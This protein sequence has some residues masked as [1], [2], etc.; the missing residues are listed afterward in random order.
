MTDAHRSAWTLSSLL[1]LLAVLLIPQSAAASTYRV[2]ECSAQQGSVSDAVIEGETT[3]YTAN[4]TCAYAPNNYLQIGTSGPVGAGQSKAWTFTAPN[5]TR[6]NRATG[7]YL[8]Q[9]QADHGG[10]QSYFFYRAVN[11]GSDQILGHQGAGNV[12]SLFDT[13][14]WPNAGAITRVGIGVECKSGATCPSRNAIYSR[15]S[16]LAFDMED[17][18][19]P[20]APVVSGP[21]L[22]GW[23]NGSRQLNFSVHDTG[24]GVSAGNTAVNGTFVDLDAFC[25]PALDGS[26]AAKQMQPCPSNGSSST[27]L[28]TSTSAFVEGDNI[29]T[30]CVYEYGEASIQRGCTDETVKVD[31]IAPSSPQGLSI[32][33]GEDWR[34]DNRFDLSWANPAQPNAPIVGASIRITG[35]GGYDA[36]TYHPG[37]DRT[38]VNDIQVPARGEYSARVYLR[39]AAGNEAAVNSSSAPLRFDDTVPMG[40]EPE[41]ANG[42]ISRAELASGYLQGWE[43]TFGLEVPPS[44]IAGYRVVVNGNSD[45]DPCSGATDPRACGGP[46]TEAGIDN[47]FRTLYMDDLGE[48]LNYVHVVPISG[49]GMRA[50]DVKHAAL[51]AD[52]TDPEATLR[53]DGGGGWINHDADLVLTAVDGLSGMEDTDEYPFDDPPTVELTVDGVTTAATP[54]VTRTV[55]AEG[56]HQVTWCSRDL[57]GNGG[58]GPGQ[59]PA[60]ASS[61]AA[62]V[63][64][65]KTAPTAAFTDSQDPDDPDRLVAPVGDALSGVVEGTISYR[66]LDGAQWKALDTSLRGGELIARVDSGDL[67]PDTTYEFRAEAT[68]AAGNW[69]SSTSKQNGEP[70]RVTG[71]FRALT[72]VADLR[73]NGRPKAR[74]KYGKRPRVS[75][76]L[77][78]VTGGAPVAGASV[79]LISTYPPGAKVRTTSTTVTTDGQGR[80]RATLPAGPSRSVV[81]GYSGDR[82]HLGVRS[83]PVKVS[84]RSK[85]TLRVPRAV[86]SDAGII[87]AGRIR[88]RGTRFQRG[89]KRLEIQVR[90]GRRWRAVGKSIRTDRR[91]RFKLPYRFTADYTRPVTYEFRAAVLRERGFPYLPSK[92]RRRTVTVTP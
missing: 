4:N 7:N 34:R 66:R 27:M 70:M 48:G 22:G 38:A 65:D 61:G 92:S 18:A 73:V 54:T 52:F 85:V 13:D 87:F 24:A 20:A 83:A 2:H 45:T 42:W 30:V 17:T 46:I 58:C 75:G 21:A 51:K 74:V 91:G 12:H 9:G 84:V 16:D 76:T 43:S 3:G 80:F 88:A 59:P 11:Q 29:V 69:V 78:T 28:D 15:I 77:L 82:R 44:G 25:S 19:A 68:D 37:A 49:S 35:P 33:G 63:R 56:V 89:G 10:H 72:S 79:E 23:I 32:V 8:V 36:T 64:I 26:G 31:T 39:D 57:A 71:P 40:K 90:I 62:T 60:G 53:G 14:F 86:D 1:V 5:G 55:S 67:A 47:R 81:A 41:R 50:T 6:I